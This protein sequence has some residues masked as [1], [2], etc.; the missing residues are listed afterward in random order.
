MES[1]TAR[2]F[3]AHVYP[4]REFKL[5]YRTATHAETDSNKK[6]VLDFNR[7]PFSNIFEN[8]I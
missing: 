6:E 8:T 4:R 3:L 2:N 1:N 7:F 5:V